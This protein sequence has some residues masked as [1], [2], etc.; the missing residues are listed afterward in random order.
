MNEFEQMI[1]L[2]MHEHDEHM[3]QTYTNFMSGDDVSNMWAY[4]AGLQHA[5]RSMQDVLA[6]ASQ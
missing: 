4:G 5:I 3:K 2:L 6:R 1:D